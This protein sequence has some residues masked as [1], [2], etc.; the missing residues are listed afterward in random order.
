MTSDESS[1]IQELQAELAESRSNEQSLRRQLEDV[2]SILNETEQKMEEFAAEKERSSRSMEAQGSR[3][4]EEPANHELRSSAS[5]SLEDSVRESVDLRDEVERLQA[6]EKLLNQRIMCLED[7]LLEVEEKYQEVEEEF[8]SEKKKVESLEAEKVSTARE[9]ELA[10]VAIQSTS[11]D[12]SQWGYSDRVDS[13]MESDL[14]Q[15]LEVA[16]DEVLSLQ[17]ELDKAR[18]QQAEASAEDGWGIEASSSAQDDVE[19]SRVREKLLEVRRQ[20]A[21]EMQLR[22]ERESSAIQHHLH[23]KE[24][25]EGELFAVKKELDTLRQLLKEKDALLA[26]GDKPDEEWGWDSAQPQGSAEI[27]TLREKLS[28]METV[29]RQHQETIRKQEAKIIALEEELATADTCR[30]E[31]EDATQQVNELQR[32][33]REVGRSSKKLLAGQ[34]FGL[35]YSG[36]KTISYPARLST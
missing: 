16:R 23:E 4:A 32:E 7:Q 5:A 3:E 33:L 18:R 12:G 24:R 34:T 15:Q 27:S 11:G 29:E 9:V 10:D 22:N 31:L 36:Y 25:I 6:V 2:R 28:E 26:A 35:L 8:I 21:D 1:R 30:E 13:V 20:L 17:K 14:Q 19:L